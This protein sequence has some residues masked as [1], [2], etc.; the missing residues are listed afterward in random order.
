MWLAHQ[1]PVMAYGKN[2]WDDFYKAGFVHV[3]EHLI[4]SGFM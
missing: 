4:G 1:E 3:N 2:E